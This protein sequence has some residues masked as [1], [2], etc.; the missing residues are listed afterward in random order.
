MIFII[1]E[2]GNLCSFN[3]VSPVYDIVPNKQTKRVLM[4][5]MFFQA[6]TSNTEDEAL[7]EIPKA[8]RG[9]TG[10]YTVLVENEHGSDTVDIPVTVL[11]KCYSKETLT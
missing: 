10:K 5:I 11:G 2:C 4:L 1:Q 7:F 3:A 9:D 8:E 6:T